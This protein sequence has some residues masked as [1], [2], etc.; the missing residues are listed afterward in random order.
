MQPA[1]KKGNG[2]RN[3]NELVEKATQ[4]FEAEFLEERFEMSFAD[5]VS[6]ASERKGSDP[7]DQPEEEYFRLT[8]LAVKMVHNE[9][10]KEYVYPKP[11]SL[12]LG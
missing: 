8:V 5:R 7:W 3:S 1:Q 6:F 10:D 2:Q 4:T 12:I 11:V 9:H